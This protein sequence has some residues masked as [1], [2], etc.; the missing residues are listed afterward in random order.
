MNNVG[1]RGDVGEKM[2]EKID[3]DDGIEILIQ[4]HIIIIPGHL[5]VCRSSIRGEKCILER[6]RE[7][8]EKPPR[9]EC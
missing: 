9:W 5:R 8:F 1:E 7:A 3:V 2:T 4:N 6:S